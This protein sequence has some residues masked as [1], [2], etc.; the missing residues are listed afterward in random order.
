MNESNYDVHE[1]VVAGQQSLI[2]VLRAGQMKLR[3]KCKYARY[4]STNVSLT[5]QLYRHILDID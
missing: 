1:N 4:D 2:Q 3:S 5:L